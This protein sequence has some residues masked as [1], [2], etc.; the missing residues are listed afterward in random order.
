ML[1]VPAI[2]IIVMGGEGNKILSARTLIELDKSLRIPFF[3]LP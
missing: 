2:E 1:R 3:G